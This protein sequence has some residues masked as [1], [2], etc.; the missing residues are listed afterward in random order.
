MKISILNVQYNWF[1]KMLNP[2]TAE[3]VHTH[4][5]THSYF[6]FKLVSALISITF[7]WLEEKKKKVRHV[8][9][10]KKQRL[11]ELLNG[12]G[13]WLCCGLIV[14]THTDFTS[15]PW[16]WFSTVMPWLWRMTASYWV[17]GS[18]TGRNDEWPF[19]PPYVRDH[20]GWQ[21]QVL[22]PHAILTTLWGEAK[23]E[24][25][26]VRHRARMTSI[27]C[28]KQSLFSHPV[29]VQLTSP[30]MIQMHNY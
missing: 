11:T 7:S 3:K 13:F 21:Q 18:E 26:G 2:R 20:L 30:K 1:I 12:K 16:R 9:A 25:K 29:T 5:Q 4:A 17:S 6:P 27:E 14:E 23:G 24:E 15:K 8:T 19:W 28:L 10:M 22:S